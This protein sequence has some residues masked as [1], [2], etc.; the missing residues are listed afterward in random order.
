[1]IVEAFLPIF[2]FI[3][4]LASSLALI[5]AILGPTAPDRVVAVDAFI[6][7]TIAT[8]VLLGAFY[9]Q[10]IYLDVA[11]IY[12]VFAFISTVAVSKYL[13]GRELHD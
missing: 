12:S 8:F 11:L 10:V 3:I 5:R 2:I 4:A 1:M 9:N 7:L 13:E 6:S